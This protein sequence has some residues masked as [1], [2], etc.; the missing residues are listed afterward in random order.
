MKPNTYVPY[1]T[2]GV[3]VDA[4]YNSWQEGRN[5]SAGQP[6]YAI[7][8]SR[9]YHSGLVQAAFMDGSV[10]TISDGI[11]LPVWRGSATRAGREVVTIEP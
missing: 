5:G 11:A 1:T 3:E 10:R 9:S 7:V 2:G 8:T 4:D 6:T